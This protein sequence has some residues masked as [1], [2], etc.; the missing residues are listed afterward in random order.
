MIR[1][2]TL[3]LALAP[4]CF[5]GPAV[6]QIAQFSGVYDAAASALGY[7][8]HIAQEH[9]TISA[10]DKPQCANRRPVQG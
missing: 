8:A 5:I 3:L 4:V 9:Q 6:P 10:L 2:A 1:S 7:G